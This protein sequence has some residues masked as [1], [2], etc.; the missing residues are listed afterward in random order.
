MT[1]DYPLTDSEKQFYLKKGKPIRFPPAAPESSSEQVNRTIQAAWLEKLAQYPDRVASAPIHIENAIIEGDLDLTHTTFQYQVVIT[2]SEFI[3]DVDFSFSLFK[4]E[5]IFSGSTFHRQANFRAVSASYDFLIKSARITDGDFTGLRVGRSLNAEDA[6][7]GA[8]DSNRVDFV[9]LKAG[10]ARFHRAQFHCKTYFTA[11]EI[12]LQF[13]FQG[14]QFKGDAGFSFIKVGGYVDF[15]PASAAASSEQS[16]H[17]QF[18]GELS[19]R[20]AVIGGQL[21][22]NKAVFKQLA[23]FESTIFEQRL[24]FLGVTFEQDVV[25]WGAQMRGGA[26]FNG[27]T[28]VQSAYFN[29]ISAKGAIEFSTNDQEEGDL[30]VCFRGKTYFTRSVIQG[31]ADFT[32][33]RF[34]QEVDFRHIQ[35]EGTAYFNPEQK[36][37]DDGSVCFIKKADFRWAKFGSYIN[38]QSVQFLESAYFDRVVVQDD[39]YFDRLGLQKQ[40]LFG[41]TARFVG[42]QFLGAVS[43]NGAQFET[44]ALFDYMRV[45]GKADFGPSQGIEKPAQPVC[46]KGRADFKGA[47]FRR[48]VSFKDAVFDHPADFSSAAAE[49]TADLTGAVFEKTVVLTDAYLRNARFREQLIENSPPGENNSQFRKDVILHGFTYQRISVAWKELL[50]L[51]SPYVRQPYIQLETTLRSTGDSKGANAVYHARRRHE[52]QEL[53]KTNKP[54]A[55]FD[56]IYDL[57]A[58]YGVKPMRLLFATFLVLTVGTLIFRSSNAALEKGAKAQGGSAFG[59]SLTGAIGMSVH[60]FLPVEVPSGNQLEPSGENIELFQRMGIP[61]TFRTYATLHHLAGFILVPLGIAA[62]AGLL[63]RRQKD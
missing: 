11:A 42:S 25:F 4:R 46:F 45:E 55:V 48:S 21:M 5:A 7:F 59:L 22:C 60:Q 18:T 2:N 15:R 57:I 35:I 30:G 63:H 9:A 28:F 53:W 36:R 37:T 6:I 33:V 1:H 13:Q 3:N 49:E 26:T 16:L 43:F 51:S 34:E 41:G 44:E 56:S 20:H 62:L 27:A 19:F 8:E 47:K 52:R 50:Q 23:D 31:D 32:G 12:D 24:F 10:L 14:A 17:V 38:F 58:G 40:T 54:R 39:A 61:L 29:Y